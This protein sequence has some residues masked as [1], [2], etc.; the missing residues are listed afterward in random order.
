[1]TTITPVTSEEREAILD[2]VREFTETELAQA[3]HQALNR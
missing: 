3:I 2:A 1:M